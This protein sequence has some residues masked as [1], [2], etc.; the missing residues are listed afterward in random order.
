MDLDKERYL[1]VASQAPLAKDESCP[2]L[3][4]PGSAE[5]RDLNPLA[6]LGHAPSTPTDSQSLTTPGSKAYSS[7]LLRSSSTY[8]MGS[9]SSVTQLSHPRLHP[10]HRR[11]LHVL[12]LFLK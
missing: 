12:S 9:K 3:S 2:S 11:A 10:P 4:T 5:Q 8:P 6:S 7:C 1:A